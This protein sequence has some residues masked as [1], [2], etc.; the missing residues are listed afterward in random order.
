MLRKLLTKIDKG[1]NYIVDDTEIREVTL[2]NIYG[3]FIHDTEPIHFSNNGHD[4]WCKIE[5]MV[6]KETAERTAEENKERAVA[7]RVA[8][9]KERM[10]KIMEE[11]KEL[12]K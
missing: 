1:Q 8:F 4:Y 5:S 11:I 10:N 7:E 2:D 9:L 3:I 6:D 12:L